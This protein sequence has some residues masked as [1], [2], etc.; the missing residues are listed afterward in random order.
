MTFRVLSDAAAIQFF[1]L[2]ATTDMAIRD[3]TP[4]PQIQLWVRVVI[5]L[6]SRLWV[7]LVPG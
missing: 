7:I 3:T 5:F 2:T 4:K 1:L 6:S